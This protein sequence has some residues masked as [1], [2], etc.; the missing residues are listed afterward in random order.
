MM[1]LYE[2]LQRRGGVLHPI[3]RSAARFGVRLYGRLRGFYFPVTEPY[4]HYR[5][6]LGTYEPGTS[7]VAR[8]L[9]R[10]GMTA[11]DVGAHLGY[12]T[13]LFARCVGEQGRVNAFEPQPESFGILVRNTKRLPH[14]RCLNMALLDQQR[15]VVL[16]RDLHSARDRVSHV[17]D[18]Q[19]QEGAAI[20]MEAVAMD[21]VLGEGV[22]PNLVKIDV[23][24]SELEV[25]RG[26]ERLLNHSPDVALIVECNPFTL[27]GN[28]L[29]PAQLLGLIQE[30][31]FEASIIVESTGRIE[32]VASADE[33]DP[34]L[35]QTKFV[36]LLCT[37]P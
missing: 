9:L 34:W 16:L 36:N 13:R 32:Q 35:R 11:I 22:R 19:R 7:A 28:G 1:R 10:P 26:M 33:L 6:L 8:K 17:A 12:Y 30:L 14:V 3:A 37:R 2:G 18:P 21:D 20:K 15:D 4:T 27:A 31:G 25:L 29:T 5:Y 24:G 23:E